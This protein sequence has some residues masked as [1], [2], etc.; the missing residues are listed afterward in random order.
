MKRRKDV[1]TLISAVILTGCVGVHIDTK[2][3]V[4]VSAGPYHRTLVVYRS[5]NQSTK[6]LEEE[7]SLTRFPH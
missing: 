1:W 4:S 2:K 7:G 5:G 3:E 6:S